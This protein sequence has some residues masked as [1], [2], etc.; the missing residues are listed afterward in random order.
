MPRNA[1]RIAV[2]EG[3]GTLVVFDNR[4]E[5]LG[6]MDRDAF[7]SF[8]RRGSGACTSLGADEVQKLP[9]WSKLV[10]M[11]N[12]YWGDNDRQIAT[13]DDEYPDYPASVC[14][15]ND[16]V[17]LTVNG[18]PECTTQ[19]QSTGGDFSGT[20]GTVALQQTEGT[21]YT[22]ETTTNRQA[23]VALGV[24]TE[25]KMGI[26]E[27]LDVTV[28]TSLTTTVTNSQGTTQSATNNQ[29]TT[30]TVTVS[31][32]DGQ[33]CKLDFTSKTCT[34]KGSGSLPFVAT[35]WVWFQYKKKTHDHWLWALNMDVILD[36]SDRSMN[37]DFNSIV[38]TDTRSQYNVVCE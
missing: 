12:D 37:L 7:S 14:A 6:L 30:S 18:D 17:D 23:S 25:V 26:P 11:A 19:S 21:S 34:T 4:G 31:Q 15:T 28:G 5:R 13:N 33:T 36:E 9:G 32:L 1:T 8:E 24:S 27:I 29:Q 20:S 10:D 22:L 3:S 35:G 38:S 16:Q 2:D